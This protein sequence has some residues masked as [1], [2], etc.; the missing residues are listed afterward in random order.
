MRSMLRVVGIVAAIFSVVGGF[1]FLLLADKLS[2]L[3][4]RTDPNE[5]PA[6][7]EACRQAAPAQRAN[8]VAAM[9]RAAGKTSLFNFTPLERRDFLQ[10]GGYCTGWLDQAGCKPLP[11]GVETTGIAVE[12]FIT[13]CRSAAG[14]Q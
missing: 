12:V 4:A 6:L 11:R 9:N 1:F 10:A 8:M 5:Y 7:L 13:T 3:R 2:P 14:L